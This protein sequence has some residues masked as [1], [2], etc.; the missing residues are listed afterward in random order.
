[1]LALLFVLLRVRGQ[2][3]GT[4]LGCPLQLAG[5][6]Y[7]TPARTAGSVPPPLPCAN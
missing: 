6:A 3:V 7:R 2:L 4:S 5:R 1:M